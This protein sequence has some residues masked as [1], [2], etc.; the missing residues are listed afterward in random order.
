VIQVR[1]GGLDVKYVVICSIEKF[2]CENLNLFKMALWYRMGVEL[3]DERLLGNRLNR[4]TTFT[5]ERAEEQSGYFGTKYT[6]N[7]SEAVKS[8][9]IKEDPHCFR[10]KNTVMVKSIIP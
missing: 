8:Q 10:C 2:V 6:Q 9:N 3:A 1:G 7:I 5:K 4:F